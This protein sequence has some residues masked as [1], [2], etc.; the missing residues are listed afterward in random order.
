MRLCL[1]FTALLLNLLAN[2][3]PAAGSPVVLVV[4][5]SISAAYGISRQQGWVNLLQQRLQQKAYPYTVVNASVSGD[6][7]RTGLTRL[8]LLLER[9]RP[10]VVII[11]LGGNDGLQ[12]LPLAQL[13]DNL[14]QMVQLSRQHGARVLLAGIRLPPNYG[15]AYNRQF[16]AV[17]RSVAKDYQLA[18]VPRLL[19][20]V[21]DRPELMQADGIHPQAGGQAGILANI[22]PRLEALL[23]PGR[24]IRDAG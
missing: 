7:S 3:A 18:F 10:A 22:W 8:P 14:E 24:P 20:G 15:P 6:T 16:A 19:H 1:L 9:H 5:D 21:A 11:E 12:G 13:Q 4:G 2:P 23:N 17:F